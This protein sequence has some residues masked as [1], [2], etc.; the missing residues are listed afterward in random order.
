MA[1][2][3]GLRVVRAVSSRRAVAG[4]N[5]LTGMAGLVGS[6][7]FE[8]ARVLQRVLRI[9]RDMGAPGDESDLPIRAVDEQTS[10]ALEHASQARAELGVASGRAC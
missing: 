8:M 7:L 2:L 4:E 1:Q 6:C 9:S 3:Q 10:G 5:P